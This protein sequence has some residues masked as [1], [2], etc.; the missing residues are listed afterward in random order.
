MR[1]KCQRETFQG[2]YYEALPLLE[3]H[4][5]EI[6]H[7]PDIALEVDVERYRTLELLD[8]LRIYTARIDHGPADPLTLIGYAVFFVSP[9]PHYR[10]SLQAVQDVLYLDP[11]QR[12]GAAGI[13]LIRFSEA[14]LK[15]EGVQ[16]VYHHVKVAHPTLGVLLDHHGYTQVETVWAKRLG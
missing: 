6:A 16:V 13:G 5:N 15:R 7:Y 10:S 1:L 11:E 4:K 2:F 3:K 14:E 8:A 12:K 9:N